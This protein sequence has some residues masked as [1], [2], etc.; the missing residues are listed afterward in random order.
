MSPLP[1]L[2]TAEQRYAFFCTSSS[3][4]QQNTTVERYQVRLMHEKELMTLLSESQVK[5]GG[6]SG[7]IFEN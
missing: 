2:Q 3:T 5:Q 4:K 1:V 7:S 6:N